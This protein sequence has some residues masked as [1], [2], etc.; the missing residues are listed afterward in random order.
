MDR[1][2]LLIAYQFPPVGGAG[3][4]RAVKF[5]KYLPE[6]GWSV[7]VLTVSNPSVPL[8]DESLCADIPPN[9]IIRKAASWEPSYRLKATVVKQQGEHNGN[10]LSN[11]GRA[12][13]A[14]LRRCATNVLQ[15]D[16][17][18]LW[19][20]A[21]VREGLRLLSEHRHHAILVS[22]PPFSSFLVGAMLS[23]KS[24]LPLVLDYRDEWSLSNR[25]W[26]N[27]SHNCITRAIQRRLQRFAVNHA[28]GLI[29]TTRMSAKALE[30]EAGRSRRNVRVE[31]IYNGFDPED[32]AQ[33]R[34]H[35]HDDG[36]RFR[37][38]HVGTL[39]RLTTASPLVKA[40][41]LLASRRPDLAA[42]LDVEIVGRSMPAEQAII[43]RLGLLPCRVVRHEYMDHSAAVD[44][45]RQS[46]ELCVLLSDVP[47]ADRVMP[48][49]T[50]EY[51]ATGRQILAIAPHGEM[52]QVLEK[53]EGIHAF[54][55]AETTV[56]AEHLAQSIEARACGRSLRPGVR[57]IAQFDRREQAGALARIL[58]ELG[59][60]DDLVGLK[61]QSGREGRSSGLPTPCSRTQAEV[62]AI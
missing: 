25:Y 7:S 11:I 59:T 12:A 49:K 19:A 3:V 5:A 1:R 21:A 20:P 53:H 34:E 44:I 62:T 2:V 13:K 15:P 6:H 18:I 26:E 42:R 23:R 55:P 43:D 38:S 32:F 40:V 29:A 4:Q 17:Q 9:T 54:S 14:F 51:L 16:A 8:L 47:G 10:R 35:P 39:W 57:Q 28:S 30:S 50:F 58:N 52:R 31:C 36:G 45:M 46:D 33:G 22:G 24:G 61:G 37:L 41:E 56:I 27:K 60:A 48:G